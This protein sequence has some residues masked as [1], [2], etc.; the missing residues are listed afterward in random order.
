[1]KYLYILQCQ[2]FFKVGISKDLK[3][4]IDVI[5]NASPFEVKLIYSIE[6]TN[7]DDHKTA[8]KIAHQRLKDLGL[9]Q[10]LEWFHGD[11]N[12]I[13]EICKDAEKVAKHKDRLRRNLLQNKAL[14]ALKLFRLDVVKDLTG[15]GNERITELL[16]GSEFSALELLK[17]NTLWE[18]ING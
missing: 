15:I 2:N 16:N 17:I 11:V 9:H 7:D 10:R 6:F 13:I 14:H 5:S 4:R 18:S 12:T 1:M 3:N 8:E